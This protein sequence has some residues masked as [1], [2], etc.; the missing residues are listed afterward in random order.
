MNKTKESRHQRTEINAMSAQEGES[1]GGS[2]GRK[3]ITAVWQIDQTWR[4][5]VYQAIAKRKQKRNADCHEQHQTKV[6]ISG[7]ETVRMATGSEVRG[8]NGRQ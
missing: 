1:F 3:P 8:D 4:D 5:E 7:H 6:S 2:F